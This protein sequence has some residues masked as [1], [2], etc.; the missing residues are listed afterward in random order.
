MFTGRATAASSSIEVAFLFSSSDSML[1]SYRCRSIMHG[2]M[3]KMPVTGALT[4][5]QA[6]NYVT[7]INPC[8]QTPRLSRLA[9]SS[10]D[11]WR[12]RGPAVKA[13]V[14]SR[15]AGAGP[16]VVHTPHTP[17]RR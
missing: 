16:H 6:K 3:R 13:T 17:S 9:A 14:T 5:T 8:L 11:E 2:K 7:P 4:V 12:A 10:F 15:Q 1:I